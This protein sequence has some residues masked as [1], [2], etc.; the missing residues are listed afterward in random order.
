MILQSSTE[1]SQN[2]Y[3]HDERSE[4]EENCNN[5]WE[6]IIPPQFEATKTFNVPKTVKDLITWALSPVNCEI[7]TIYMMRLAYADRG[8]TNA[9]YLVNKVEHCADAPQYECS[10]HRF[11]L[12]TRRQVTTGEKDEGAR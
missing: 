10:H 8:I 11:V 1:V 3:C 2:H 9:T 6:N 7:F 12:I 4:Q 5:G